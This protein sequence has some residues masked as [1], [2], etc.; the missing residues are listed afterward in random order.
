MKITKKRINNKTTG[1]KS[2]FTEN[3]VTKYSGLIFFKDLKEAQGGFCALRFVGFLI[4][5]QIKY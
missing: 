4:M 2:F 1:L 3:N 5:R